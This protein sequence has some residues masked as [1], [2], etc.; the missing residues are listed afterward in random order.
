LTI[1]IIAE[2]LKNNSGDDS[3]QTLKNQC[4]AAIK[5]ME[6]NDDLKNN[7]GINNQVDAKTDESSITIAEL[8]LEI[9][10]LGVAVAAGGK[11]SSK[12]KSKKRKG[13]SKR[14]RTRRHMN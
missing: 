4:E 1:K 12:S 13:K 8:L 11:R 3:L 14:R 9:A 6:I 10:G 2:Q 7:L 5:I